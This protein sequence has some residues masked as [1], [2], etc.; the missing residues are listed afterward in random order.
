MLKL[1]FTNNK[2]NAV[3]LV[4]PKVVI[5]RNTACDLVV[6]HPEIDPKHAEIRVNHEQLHLVLLAES[7]NTLLNGRVVPVRKLVPLK[8]RDIIRLAD[9]ELEVIDPKQEARAAPTIPR[10][11]ESTGWALKA[12]HPSLSSR[13]FPLLEVNLV[14]RSS[15][16]D[17]TL[18]A[19]HLS[20]RHAEL[21]V[22]DGLLYVKDLGSSN[23]TFV[24]GKQVDHARIKRGDDLRFDTLSFGVIGPT[25]D[26]DKTTL[27]VVS[28]K[29]PPAASSK[30]LSSAVS[31][32]DSMLSGRAGAKPQQA[33][34]GNCARRP[35]PVS[36]AGVESI[37]PT[38]QA[39]GR[40]SLI[41]AALLI[42]IAGGGF[43]V[44]QS[45]LI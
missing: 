27:R 5:G 15:E 20:R 1:R 17:I 34:A 11:A 23:G 31:G 30:T 2:Q 33:E 24:N 7:G 26:L 45:G 8:A 44:W 6:D 3:W 9:S 37:E 4:E 22:K 42:L 19:A 41:G 43:L 13:V 10:Q 35:R 28:H 21:I 25:D 36:S 12:N 14:G 16:C 40:G 18:G 29:N 38:P 39:A 32:H